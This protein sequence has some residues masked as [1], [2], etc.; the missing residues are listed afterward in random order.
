MMTSIPAAFKSSPLG[1]DGTGLKDPFV[2][3]GCGIHVLMHKVNINIT[4]LSVSESGLN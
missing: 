1:S 2:V 3:S 4:W